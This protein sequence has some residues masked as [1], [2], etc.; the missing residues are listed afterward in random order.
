MSFDQWNN[1]ADV[2]NLNQWLAQQQAA[3]QA[4]AKKKGGRG[5]TLTSL[6]SEAGGTGGA[7]G[8][9]AIGT[10]ILPG[11]GTLLGA[12]IG[13]FLGGFGGRVAENEVRDGRL[14]LG[15]ALTEGAISGISGAGP[16]RAGKAVVQGAKALGTKGLERAGATSLE[17][18]VTQAA[19]EP[20]K[21]SLQGRLTGMG[22]HLLTNQYG[23]ISK[24]VA[25]A[26][27]P[28]KTLGQ[29][30][31]LG[32]TSPQDVERVANGV[33]G[34]QGLINKAVMSAVG[35]S[36]TVPVTGV[37]KVLT[38]AINE[39]GLVDADAKSVTNT[40][41][42]Q[43][44]KIQDGASPSKVLG[45]MKALEKRAADLKGNGGNYKMADP[46]REDQARVLLKV[47]DEL[48]GSL[49]KS[50]G[51]DKNVANVLTPELRD[52]LVSLHPDNAQWINHV[53]NNIMKST[54]VKQLRS[55]MA[56]FV[57]ARQIIDEG[58]LNSM[59]VGGRVA[60]TLAN[61]GS[62]GGALATGAMQLAKGPVARV[63]GSAL[64]TAGNAGGDVAAGMIK[65]PALGKAGIVGREAVGNTAKTLFAPAP[66]NAQSLED[67]LMQQN[68]GQDPSM[69]PG[70]LDP[71]MQEP[72]S[73]MPYSKE[74]LLADIQR[75]PKNGAKY[76]DYY[77]NLDAIFN[78]PAAK[79]AGPGYTKP[80]SQQYAQG[81]TGSNS[82][83]QLQNILSQ[84]PG[85]VNRAATPGQNIPVVGSLISRGTNTTA[86]RGAGNNILNSIARINTGANMPESERKFYEQTY[87][88]QPGDPP[89]AIQQKLATLRQFFAPIT[90]YQSS[91]SGSL[92]DALMQAQQQGAY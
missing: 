29:L 37:K 27:N 74:A 65:G 84:D 45:I 92:Q 16:I 36:G 19:T 9:A 72:Q 55:S 67:A 86:Y 41:N 50:A 47:R 35:D 18:A 22:N 89:E 82:I 88:P 70:N 4:P 66:A 49:Y 52:Q 33:T 59:T 80:T 17:D 7:L 64:R 90:N 34:S 28:V 23:A 75:D 2:V 60:N 42:A 32:I 76:I 48:E 51:A 11:V 61:G 31:D 62:L 91:P 56:P 24:P 81:I 79:D 63:A 30:A 85:A 38:T 3:K 53:D 68:G 5:G 12:G 69:Q 43:L 87:L 78:P 40:V 21:T 46:K 54:S 25:R 8:G 58:D 39:H 1:Q 20:A 77:N 83:D 14:G 57:R 73:Q 26:T 15:D 10:A 71:S 6:I 13:G 44:N